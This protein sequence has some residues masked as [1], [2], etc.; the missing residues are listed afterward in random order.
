MP[1]RITRI[2]KSLF[3]AVLV[4]TCGLALADPPSRVARLSYVSGQASFLAGGVNDWSHVAVNRPLVTGDRL[5]VDR[6]ARAELQ[7]GSSAVRLG[8]S[9]SFALLNLDDRTAQFELSEGSMM[10]RVRRLDSGEVVEVD[11]PNLAYLIR[12]PGSYRVEV[13][14][15]G[16]ST[17]VAA[18]TG[19]AEVY[20]EGRAFLTSERLGYR[21]YGTSLRDYDTFAFGQA[22]DLERFAATRD[23]ALDVSASR[24]YVS[25]ELIGS[26]DLD[27]NGAWRR[28]AD[29]GYVW[30]PA[31][32]SSDWAPY[33]DGNWAWVEPWGWTWI[34][35]APWGF[36]TSHYGRW[37][38]VDNRWA[39]VPGPASN[40]PVYAPALV[41]FVGGDSMNA[42]GRAVAW[43]PLGPREVYRPSYATSRD[44]FTRVNASNSAF[45]R[46]RLVT[47]Y[48]EPR[49][50]VRYTN[51]AVPGA[52][53][54]VLAAAFAESRPV[55]RE[56]V[57][58]TSNASAAAPVV[59]V[60]SVA[61][62]HASV[63]GAGAPGAARPP[64]PV[65]ARAVVAHAAPP[66]P[67]V[68]F[69]A[70]QQELAQNIGKPHDA[71]A[72]AAARPAQPASTPAPAVKVV[73]PATASAV[74]PVRPSAAGSAPRPAAPPPPIAPAPAAPGAPAA[75]TP[76][77]PPRP[78][79]P[80]SRAAPPVPAVP[81]P[82]LAPSAPR[83]AAPAAQVAPPA[84]AA[85]ASREDRGRANERSREE[86]PRGRP[87]LGA[88]SQRPA[89]PAPGAAPA[90]A[91]AAVPAPVAPVT[92][93]T[94][95]APPPA[96]REERRPASA[97]QEAA[98]PAAALPRAPEAPR[99]AP[100]AAPTPPAP[101]VA[102]PPAVARPAEPP[103]PVAPPP[104][105]PPPPPQKAPEPPPRA[106][107]PPP[108][109]HAP[110]AAPEARPAR[111]QGEAPP[112]RREAASEA[113]KPASERRE[114][115]KP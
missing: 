7:L 20:G 55:A 112:P 59:V 90:P 13:E 87:D 23:R 89:Q 95:P 97:P 66:P 53:V 46:N 43:F 28:T 82:V 4:A 33:R 107:A 39:W 18:R 102:A 34:D 57:R 81:A 5:W 106:N 94:P 65:Q 113:R 98:R 80:A 69:A 114:E 52:I 111:P 68:P 103:R 32:V 27:R 61:P 83:A 105:P 37:A 16:S 30:I 76:P 8:P 38:R 49:T 93:V 45:D 101:Q 21:F 12:R 64:Q 14:P 40:R 11:T 100:R 31:R 78:A 74:A 104:P 6:G 58:M 96:T 3:L 108:P 17:L 75:A 19:L 42:G 15:D 71:A 60:P 77:Q 110:A 51:Q 35:D 10:I 62:Q 115:R 41:A 26:D 109:A 48:N 22:D 56:R 50:E 47:Y 85:A 99:E 63:V 29:L 1:T 36:A 88:G 86:G 70:R 54:A 91:P 2:A 9:S 92:P 72:V 84:P 67:P 73:Q 25:P 79:E 44:Y 24:R